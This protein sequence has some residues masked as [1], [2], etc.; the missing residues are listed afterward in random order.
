MNGS[1]KYF[2]IP[3]YNL[4]FWHNPLLCKKDQSIDLLPGYEHGNSTYYEQ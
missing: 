3:K 1:V 4:F 2:S